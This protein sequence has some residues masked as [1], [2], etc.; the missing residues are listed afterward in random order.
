MSM[1]LLGKSDK[2]NPA[3]VAIDFSH[4]AG[5]FPLIEN[6]VSIMRLCPAAGLANQTVVG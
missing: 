4:E 3:K 6:V 1:I 2:V 5:I